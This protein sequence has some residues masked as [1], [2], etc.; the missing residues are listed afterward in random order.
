MSFVVGKSKQLVEL[1]KK[2][3]SEN[4]ET[5]N[6]LDLLSGYIWKYQGADETMTFEEFF[7]GLLDGRFSNQKTIAEIQK[8]VKWEMLKRNE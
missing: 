7:V 8:R 6:N 5:A 2:A 1:I 4:L 3:F